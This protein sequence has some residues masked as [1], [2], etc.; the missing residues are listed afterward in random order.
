MPN[1]TVRLATIEDLP[2]IRH[3][4][5]RMVAE[6]APPYPTNILGSLDSFT[7]SMALALTA[8][9][10]AAWVLLGQ[11]ATSTTPDA[12]LGYELQQRA[13]GE[14]ARLAFIHFIYTVPE[15]CGQGL[16]TTLLELAAE[17][18][19]A[20]GIAYVEG[21]SIPNDTRFHDLGFT[22]Y[23][24]RGVAPLAGFPAAI[25]ARRRRR[26]NGHTD[27]FAIPPPLTPEERDDDH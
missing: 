25:E 4:W 21:T 18:M 10:A 20:Q 16:A 7:R 15:A 24:H 22:V 19:A 12:F 17:H 3:L 6:N 13:L 27:D 23:E 26:G 9:P 8:E 2:W 5:H 11:R 14:P 1:Y